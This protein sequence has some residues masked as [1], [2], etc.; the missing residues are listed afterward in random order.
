MLRYPDNALPKKTLAYATQNIS[1][2]SH[3]LRVTLPLRANRPPQQPPRTSRL[4]AGGNACFGSSRKS[5]LWMLANENR[6]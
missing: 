1:K 2:P 4:Y 5:K 6:C 3:A